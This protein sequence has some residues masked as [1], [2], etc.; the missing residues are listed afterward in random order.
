MTD[1]P[2]IS[3]A[4]DLAWANALENAERTLADTDDLGGDGRIAA[5]VAAAFASIAYD[6]HTLGLTWS[7]IAHLAARERRH[8]GHLRVD[9]PTG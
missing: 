6:A 3:P 9:R 8:A 1:E 7:D 2:A 4:A 5:A